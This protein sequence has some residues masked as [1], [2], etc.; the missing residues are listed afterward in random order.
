MDHVAVVTFGVKEELA[1]RDCLGVSGA[2]EQE[3]EQGCQTDAS[4]WFHDGWPDCWGYRHPLAWVGSRRSSDLSGCRAAD[5]S[6]GVNLARCVSSR[7]K[8]S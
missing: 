3:S 2:A 4:D 5:L 6:H 1:G 8:L 7:Y